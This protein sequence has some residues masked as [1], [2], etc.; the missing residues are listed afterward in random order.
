M[1]KR[2][3]KKKKFD[4]FKIQYKRNKHDSWHTPSLRRYGTPKLNKF[5]SKFR[6]NMWFICQGNHV[7]ASKLYSVRIKGYWK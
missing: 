2:K 3:L 4:Y 6:A 1:T 5:K 7:I